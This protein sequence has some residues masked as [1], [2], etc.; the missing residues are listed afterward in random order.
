MHPGGS[1]EGNKTKRG[2]KMRAVLEV[3]LDTESEVSASH[4]HTGRKMA[5]FRIL[6]ARESSLSLLV[7]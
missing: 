6:K 4:A 5:Y 1:S 2:R 3:A 7:C